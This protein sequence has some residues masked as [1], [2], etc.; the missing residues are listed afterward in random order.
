MN[1]KLRTE[2]T[3]LMV[4]RKKWKVIRRGKRK[5]VFWAHSPLFSPDS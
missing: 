3:I 5:T 1:K 4:Q 2:S